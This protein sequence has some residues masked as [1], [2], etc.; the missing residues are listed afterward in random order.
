V[1]HFIFD[2]LMNPIIERWGKV[3]GNTEERAQFMKFRQGR[4][5]PETIP[6][7]PEILEQAL[8][9]WYVGQLLNRITKENGAIGQGVKLL[10]HFDP[11]YHEGSNQ[12]AS[13]GY[14][15]FP[16][17]L[18]YPR[19]KVPAHDYAPVVLSSIAIAL[20]DCS[21]ANSLEPLMPYH[22]LMYLGGPVSE[23]VESKDLHVEISPLLEA[24]ILDGNVGVEAPT[25]DASRAGTAD[26]SSE[27]RRAKAIA[28]FQECLSEVDKFVN[29]TDP[30]KR[31]DSLVWQMRREINRSLN[32]LIRFCEEVSE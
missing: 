9:G 16:Y 24:W 19:D 6:L 23:T 8:R 13:R 29:F 26:S 1:H 28:Y 2:N 20:A 3:K 31:H 11:T 27:V 25:P 5:L 14:K 22:E 7:A 12:N 15:A 21:N 30:I 10:V 32:T 18:L 4:P 17:P